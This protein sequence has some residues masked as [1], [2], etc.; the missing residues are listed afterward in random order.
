MQDLFTI[1]NTQ[2]ARYLAPFMYMP[3]VSKK[4]ERKAHKALIRSLAILPD[5]IRSSIAQSDPI[6]AQFILAEH[7]KREVLGRLFK[8]NKHPPAWIAKLPQPYR[9]Y[10]ARTWAENIFEDTNIS[11]DFP[12]TG[13]GGYSVDISENTLIGDAY[14]T[15]KIFRLGGIRQLAWLTIAVTKEEAREVIPQRYEHRR[16]QHVLDVTA[17]AN[18]LAYQ[19]QLPEQERNTLIL[20][21]LTHDTLTPAGGDTT[22]LLD[23]EFF[24]EDKQ[25]HTLFEDPEIREL[26]ARYNIPKELLNQTVLGKGVLGGLLDIADKTAYV[27]RDMWQIARRATSPLTKLAEED[28]AHALTNTYP[29]ICNA[30]QSVYVRDDRIVFADARALARFLELRALLFRCLYFNI[31]TR[32]SEFV[33]GHL[34]LKELINTG[35]LRKKDLLAWT[36]SQLDHHIETYTHLPSQWEFGTPHRKGFRDHI[37]MQEMVERQKEDRENAVMSEI[38][39]PRIKSGTE[40]LVQING[41]IGPLHECAP[42]LA[43][44]IDELAQTKDPFRVYWIPI[45]SMPAKFQSIAYSLLT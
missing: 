3:P 20:A 19:T 27:S 14:R 37:S 7:V 4:K 1:L 22:K 16:L 24:D 23:R 43:N 13:I 40:Y 28:R 38:L 41:R 15:F 12:Y 30:W 10:T 42:E 9:S 34:I 18:L 11:G 32:F 31:D 2:D 35:R 21:A 44:P 36:D 17:I 25:Y 5:D 39:P 6:F 8:P 26:L 45:S 33:V 29:N